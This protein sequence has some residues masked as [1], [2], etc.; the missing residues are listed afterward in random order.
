MFRLIGKPFS[1]IA[2]PLFSELVEEIVG[3]DSRVLLMVKS[4]IRFVG[5]LSAY[6]VS[7]TRTMT[8]LELAG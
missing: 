7:V 8:A 5:S 3:L 1:F 6:D 4:I 2:G